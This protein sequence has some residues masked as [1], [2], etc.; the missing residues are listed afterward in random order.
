M[1]SEVHAAAVSEGLRRVAAREPPGYMDKKKDDEGPAG[2]YLVWEQTVCEAESR[3]CDVLIVTGDVKED[4]WR[5]EE[6]ERRGPRIE[7]VEEMRR[8]SGARLF[9]FHP[10][11]LLSVA[12]AQPRLVQRRLGRRLQDSPRGAAALWLDYKQ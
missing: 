6:G 1:T 5:I 2:D 9:I 12:C 3:R 8:R 11:R 4:W 10:T 7:L